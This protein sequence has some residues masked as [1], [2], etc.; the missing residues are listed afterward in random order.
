MLYH[1]LLQGFILTIQW[2][3]NQI[4]TFTNLSLQYVYKSY[5]LVFHDQEIILL[6]VHLRLSFILIR[7]FWF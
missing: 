7:T 4:H 2:I 6:T 5:D 1:I 3:S